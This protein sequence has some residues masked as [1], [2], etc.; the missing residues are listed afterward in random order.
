MVSV[1]IITQ[2]K[3]IELGLEQTREQFEKGDGENIIGV[4]CS[5]KKEYTKPGSK[6]IF[7]EKYIVKKNGGKELIFLHKDFL[8]EKKDSGELDNYLKQ[9]S[10]IKCDDTKKYLKNEHL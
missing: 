4:M 10:K 1:K 7:L 6:E 8:K 3:A 2:Q 5:A 9:F